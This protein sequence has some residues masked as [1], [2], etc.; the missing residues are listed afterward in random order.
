MA[1][2]N[3]GGQ[4]PELKNSPITGEDEDELDEAPFDEASA[5]AVCYF[6]D[7][8]FAAGSIVRSGSL[9]LRCEFGVWVPISGSDPD[10]P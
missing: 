2:A 10:N 5:D 8:S 3:V 4:D 6:N 1:H 9:M 7:E